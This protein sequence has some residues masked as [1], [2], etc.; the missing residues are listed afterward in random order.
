MSE[1]APRRGRRAAA[2]AGFAL[3]ALAAL[4]LRAPVADVPF[5]R[6]EGEYAY[7]AWRWLEGD[8]PYRDGFDQKP[9][10]VLAAYA[11]ILAAA[12]ASPR[13][14]HWGAQLYTLATL[15]LLL[16]LGAR[17]ASLR[18]GA[19]A[20]VLC[21]FAT[22]APGTLGN[23][24]NVELFALLPLVA[25]VLAAWRGSESGRSADAFGAGAAAGA[26]LA[27][28]PVVAPL[29]AFAFALLLFRRPRDAAGRLRLAALFAAGGAALWLPLLGYFAAH[30]A[31]DDL[32]DATVRFNLA[33]AT[34]VSFAEYPAML[35]EE[36]PR[37]LGALGPLLAAAALG[38]GL[39]ALRGL[40]AAS[41]PP[42]RADR[43]W[44][45]GWLACG[46][47]AVAAGGYFRAHYF[48]LAVPPLALVAAL[49]LD[50][51]L[52]ALAVPLRTR[53][54]GIATATA[55]VLLA[56]VLATPWY[57]LPGDP[58]AKSRRIYGASPFPESAALGAF[59]AG[60]SEP[61]DTVFVYGSE[62]QILVHARRR[63][64]SRYVLAY[65]YLFGPTE[66]MRARQREVLGELRSA[67]PRFVVGVFLRT[68]L[69]EARTS[70]LE[71]RLG[72][73]ETLRDGYQPI[74]V[75]E[76]PRGDA[77]E[78]IRTDP[79]TL[80]VWGG[81]ALFERPVP[82]GLIVVWERGAPAPGG[83]AP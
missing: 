30:G 9:P 21:A 72:L 77:P 49:G 14:V 46:L 42:L 23:A 19:A 64:A 22:T 34:S 31:L 63:S 6:D 56:G 3:V 41:D 81:P 59:L 80:R 7:L 33:Y 26:A 11:L 8:V 50:D 37:A 38:L 35:R 62:P 79:G 69:L 82:E 24:A 51:A 75:V 18:V 78:P 73:A 16:R 55:A 32:Y 1:A 61:G 20:A 76:P 17:V 53:A 66:A 27:F 40:G 67:P 2:L 83:A 65:H 58:A 10:G 71:L 68:S 36:L 28:K 74:A 70:P 13:A 4:L 43:L 54:A 5:E 45:L 44:L 60:R 25:S 48:Q 12:G 52:A 15:A 47:A 57:F 29:A 39:R